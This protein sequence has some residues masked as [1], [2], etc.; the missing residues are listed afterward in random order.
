M[1]ICGIRDLCNAVVFFPCVNLDTELNLMFGVWYAL[2][3]D[4]G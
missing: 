2:Q 1:G 3:I 4:L